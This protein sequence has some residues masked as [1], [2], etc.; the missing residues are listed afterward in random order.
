MRR[1]PEQTAAIETMAK[2]VC[3]DAGAGAG[4]TSVL[5]DRIVHLIEQKLATL[6]EITAITFTDK[7]AAEMKIRLREACRAK[8]PRGDSAEMSRWRDMERRVETSR[9]ATIHS[10]CASLLREHALRMGIDPDFTVL[11]EAEATLLR[12]DTVT[13]SVHDLLNRGEAAA[14]RAATEFGTQRLINLM[15]YLLV[16]RGVIERIRTSYPPEDPAALLIYWRDLVEKESQTRMASIVRDP[17]VK[18]FREVLAS[19]DGQCLNADDKCEALRRETLASL[20][21]LIGGGSL[22]ETGDLLKKLGAISLQA[23]SKSNWNPQAALDALKKALEEVRSFARK[24]AAISFDE[25]NE[26]RATQITCDVWAVLEKVSEAYEAAKAARSGRDFDDLL[27]MTLAI[28]R[29]NQEIRARTARG[30]KFLLIDEFQDTDTTQIEIARL[31][32]EHP[33]GPSLFVVG[34]AKQS[35]YD[36]RGAEVE[37][38]QEARSQAGEVI[39]LARNFRTVPELLAFVNDVFKRSGLLRSVEPDYVPLKTHRSGTSECRIELLIPEEIEGALADEYRSEEAKL[40]AW[41]LDEMCHGAGG[42]QVY[43]KRAERMRLAEFGDAVL[44]FRSMS[45]VYLYEEA[46]REK[47]IPYNVV[48]GA[49]FYDRQ[50][51]I[52][53]RNLLT[54]L[55]DPHDEMALLGFLRGPLA[56]LSDES[57]VRLCGKMSLIHAMR[58]EHA[59]EDFPQSDRLRA[60]RVLLDDLRAHSDSPLPAFL[61][62]LLD[63][64]GYEAIALTQFLGVQKAYNVRK[65]VDLADDFVR[66]RPAKLAAFV[67]YLDEIAGQEEIREGDASLQ[68]EGSGAVTL[69]TIHKAKGLEFP[70]VVIP[71]LSRDRRGPD[72]REVAVHRTLGMAA[73]TTDDHGETV[74]PAIYELIS[75]AASEKGAAEHARILYVAMTRARDWLL[76]G[77]SPK[78]AHNSWLR[79][80]DG[81]YGLVGRNHGAEI[82]GDGWNAVVRRKAPEHARPEAEASGDFS[83]EYAA[84]ARRSEPIV[85]IARTRRVFSVSELLDFF[86]G[87]FDAHEAQAAHGSARDPLLRGTLVHRMFELWPFEESEA[88]VP[89]LIES[90][91]P[92]ECPAVKV[93]GQMEPD[94][95]AAAERFRRSLLFKRI[96]A[97]GG[98]QREKPF[99]L[100]VGDVLVSGT[101]DALLDDGTLIDYKTGQPRKDMQERYE[102][103]LRLYAAA[104][105]KLSGKRPPA[106]FVYYADT[107][108]H[109]AVDVSQQRIEEALATASHAITALSQ[110]SVG[111]KPG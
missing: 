105:M 98:L 67:Q 104:V 94:M 74:K 108:G 22:S 78:P 5:I 23:G 64:T 26:M 55:S 27:S 21:R 28:L 13:E 63:R 48:A 44:L 33:E 70:I 2:R 9:I 68:P 3:V 77:G 18:R 19:F 81:L 84:L 60:A 50:E 102:W 30:I 66:T 31:L 99:M 73:R 103:Q 49:G 110:D 25:P 56:G 86:G 17:E 16:R 107:G 79:T 47:G 61:R 80:L 106:A 46:L 43:D 92:R 14:I 20:E 54:V 11:A 34:D 88:D 41:R 82:S 57:L 6:D 45:S 65:I 111:E 69:M 32:V 75:D 4:K 12:V 8:A 10:F 90:F 87:E 95:R 1:T 59:P 76:M 40:I 35:I 89:A 38:F 62:Y 52:D 24:N 83:V 72:L 58:A 29:E 91:L 101:I 51:V 42:A 15:G 71:D 100:R 109:V 37:V 53:L 97:A 85:E 7:A 36:F 39:P 96:T 93:R